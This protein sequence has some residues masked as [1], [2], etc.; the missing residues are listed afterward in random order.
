[1]KSL[2]SLFFLFFTVTLYSQNRS[3]SDINVVFQVPKEWK[4][5]SDSLYVI[6]DLNKAVNFWSLYLADG[7]QP[8][9]FEPRNAAGACLAAFGIKDDS[10]VNE[11]STRLTEINR[12]EVY[13]LS[14]DNKKYVVYVK[15]KKNIPIAYKMEIKNE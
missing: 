13:S 9:R 15:V 7:R 10:P 5:V 1:M 3:T 6:R 8:W 4:K 14:V 12:R 11:F 2:L